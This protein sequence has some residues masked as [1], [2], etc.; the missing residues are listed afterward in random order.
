[1]IRSVQGSDL[2]DAGVM[3]RVVV[4]FV[5]EP[6]IV[7][8]LSLWVEAAAMFHKQLNGDLLVFMGRTCSQV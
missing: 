4:R 5:I 8:Y 6:N 3:T 7:V 1:M 2:K